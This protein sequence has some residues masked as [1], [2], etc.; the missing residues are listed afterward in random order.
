[1]IA[2]FFLGSKWLR[3]LAGGVVAVLLVWGIGWL[4]LPPWLKTQL[5]TRLGDQLGRRVTV[6]QVEFKPW[7]LELTLHDF[8]VAQAAGTAP[9]AEALPQLSVKR[10]YIDAELQSVLR[11]APVVDAITLEAPHL[12]L[13]HLGQGRYDFDD[14]LSRLAAPPDKPSSDPLR[15]ALYN[16]ALV[17]GAIDFTDTPHHKTHL[18]SGLVIKIPF[19][20]NLDSQREV[21]VTPQLAFSLNGSQFD[22]NAQSTPFAQSQ[23]TALDLKLS[24]LDLAPYLDYQPAGMPVRL[25]S[26]VL[27]ADLKLKFEK[28]PDAKM[29]MEGQVQASKVKLVSATSG[30]SPTSADLLEFGKL[31]IQVKDLQPLLQDVQ[32]A[33][34]TLTE[35]RVSLARDAAGQLNWLSLFKQDK[36]AQANSG[37][38]AQPWK[39]SLDQLAVRAGQLSWQDASIATPSS[40]QLSALDV[41]AKDFKW[42]MTVAMPF[43]GNVKLDAAGLSF[44]G[45]ATDQSAQLSA[46]V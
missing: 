3:R 45:S 21:V 29:R 18:L 6:G 37:K 22:S 40:L 23:K 43:E 15:F 26:A 9:Q 41:T 35:P 12:R 8:T 5:E 46:Q 34:L 13:T 31:S 36:T 25:T 11:L 4:A 1:M 10:I 32:L 7:S 16:L 24:Q 33:S 17:D 20:S 38:A 30:K 19:L 2:S 28:S 39:V 44:K 27:D 14:V 42:P